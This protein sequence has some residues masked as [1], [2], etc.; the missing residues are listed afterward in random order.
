MLHPQASIYADN[1]VSR[2]WSSGRW[3]PHPTP[4]HPT[5]TKCQRSDMLHPQA[6]I[7]ADNVV[8]RTWSSGRWYPHPTPPHPTCLHRRTPGP[9]GIY[10]YIYMC[11]FGSLFVFQ[12]L[13]SVLLF[14]PRSTKVW[15]MFAAPPWNAFNVSMATNPWRRRHADLWRFWGW[16]NFVGIDQLNNVD[17]WRPST[18]SFKSCQM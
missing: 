11:I 14:P 16:Y 15:E 7:Y 3:Y 10:I 2:T 17:P 6:S 9:S 13:L 8:W 12:F 4:P 1:V 18:S 5:P